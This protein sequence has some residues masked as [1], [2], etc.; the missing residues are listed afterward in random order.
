MP[1]ADAQQLQLCAVGG[2]QAATDLSGIPERALWSNQRAAGALGPGLYGPAAGGFG[3]Q[4]PERRGERQPAGGDALMQRQPDADLSL[5]GGAGMDSGPGGG[6]GDGAD[7][8]RS[9]ALAA[10]GRGDPGARGVR[11][12]AGGDALRAGGYSGR[13]STCQRAWP[14]RTGAWC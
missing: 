9:A 1:E 6:S 13:A 4:R 11:E 2:G 8:L 10:A 7:W 3:D 12:R 14:S 5:S